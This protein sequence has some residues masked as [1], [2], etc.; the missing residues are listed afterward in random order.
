MKK[1]TEQHKNR[2]L[3]E[4]YDNNWVFLE[5]DAKELGML[6]H[7]LLLDMIKTGELEENSDNYGNIFYQIPENN[8]V[9]LLKYLINLNTT[10]K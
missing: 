10:E 1:S 8:R 3:K 7:L 4:I 9:S 2:L 6:Y 5:S